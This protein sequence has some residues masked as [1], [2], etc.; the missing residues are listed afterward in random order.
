M[1]ETRNVQMG[2]FFLLF[3]CAIRRVLWSPSTVL[4]QRSD[5]FQ[6]SR[7]SSRS[8]A[9]LDFMASGG[10]FFFEL[11][12]MTASLPDVLREGKE[13][14]RRERGMRRRTSTLEAEKACRVNV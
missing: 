4:I 11:G 10:R 14:P 9:F 5:I 6:V 2:Q 12:I 3:E 8:S 1:L 13:P 7:S